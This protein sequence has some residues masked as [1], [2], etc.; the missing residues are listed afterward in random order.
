LRTDFGARL[1]FI[2][3][4]ATGTASI[5]VAKQHDPTFNLVH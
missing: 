1:R 5:A 4:F 2:L 3:L